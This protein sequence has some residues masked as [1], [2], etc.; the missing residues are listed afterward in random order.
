MRLTI[1][2]LQSMV[3]RGS[4]AGFER[5]VKSMDGLDIQ[6]ESSDL[7]TLLQQTKGMNPEKSANDL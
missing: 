6:E 5:S 7:E 3:K 1:E 2:D 4:R